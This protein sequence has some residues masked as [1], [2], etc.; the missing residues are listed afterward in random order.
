MKV[1]LKQFLLNV[2][3]FMPVGKRSDIFV[4][5]CMKASEE[6]RAPEKLCGSLVKH[7][8]CREG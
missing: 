4:C 5:T 7:S 3:G 1:S 8:L 6:G 2:T